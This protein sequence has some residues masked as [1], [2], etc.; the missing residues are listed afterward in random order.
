MSTTEML[1]ER[2]AGLGSVAR[3]LPHVNVRETAQTFTITLGAI[4]ASLALFTVY[5]LVRYGVWPLDLYRIMYA[6]SFGSRVSIE[7][8]LLAAAPLI[9]VAL[10]T[11]VPARVGLIIIGGDGALALGG[12]AAAMAGLALKNLPGPVLVTA[13]ALAG[14]TAGGLLIALAGWLRHMRGVNETISSLLLSLICIGIFNFLVEGP[15]R[16]PNPISAN[17]PSTPP[18][19]DIPLLGNMFG[20]D[21]HWGL[22]LGVIF[23]VLMWLLM[24][25]T[26]FGFAARMVGGNVKAAQAAGLPVGLLLMVPCLLAGAAAGLAGAV[27]IAAV[28]LQ[29][30]SSL[31]SRAVLSIGLLGVLVSFVARHNPLAII[32]VALLIGGVLESSQSLQSQLSAYGVFDASAYVLLGI[33]IVMIILSETLYGRFRIFLPRDVQKAMANQ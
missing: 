25:H 18:I 13:M 3:F 4:V 23:C 17:K 24:Y 28:Q 16:D 6:G 5:M 9:L 19:A 33:L 14:M 1:P 27:E 11:A 7:S 29:A 20:Y 12:L 10:C 2:R 15:L 21:V 8:T 26:T 31:F 32:A 30:N 22:G